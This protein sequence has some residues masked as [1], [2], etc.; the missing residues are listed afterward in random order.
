VQVAAGLAGA[1]E[2]SQGFRCHAEQYR[3]IRQN[4]EEKSEKQKGRETTNHTNYTNDKR[5]ESHGLNTDETLILFRV[6]SVFNLWLSSLFEFF[7]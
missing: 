2:Q 7:V 5:R 4:G 6:S 3:R 1:K